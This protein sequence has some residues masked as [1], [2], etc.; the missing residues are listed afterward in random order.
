MKPDNAVFSEELSTAK[1]TF[2]SYV[3]QV[4]DIGNQL[5]DNAQ[6][7]EVLSVKDKN[8]KTA[9]EMQATKVG[10][11]VGGCTGV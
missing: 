7:L 4:N 5:T 2:N 1:M 9:E 3:H 8:A 10:V 6:E 11:G